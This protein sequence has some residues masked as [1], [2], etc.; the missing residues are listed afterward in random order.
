MNSMSLERLQQL[1]NE[2]Q[3]TMISDSFQE[4]MKSLNV[5]RLYSNPEPLFNAREMN[6]HYDFKKS[7][8]GILGISF[9]L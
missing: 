2:R 8:V 3:E 9:Y 1:E 4:W 5:S 7:K 6:Q